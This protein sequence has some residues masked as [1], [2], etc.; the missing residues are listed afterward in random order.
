MM[1][2]H[3]IDHSVVGCAAVDGNVIWTVYTAPNNIA[4]IVSASSRS[5]HC[6]KCSLL[7]DNSAMDTCEHIKL[8]R[9]AQQQTVNV[10]LEQPVDKF[11]YVLGE[12]A[13]VIHNSV[14]LSPYNVSK[15]QKAITVMQE[16]RD[17]Y[18]SPVKVP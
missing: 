9:K 18:N 3:R 1:N 17:S 13:E 8:V 6:Y 14:V 5:L 7:S 2:F 15:M 12:L 11:V 10:V 16:L 4:I